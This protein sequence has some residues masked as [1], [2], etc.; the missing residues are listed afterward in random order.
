LPEW[1]CTISRQ[2]YIGSEQKLEKNEY[3]SNSPISGINGNNND[4][5]DDKN[6]NDNDDVN[7]N[8]NNDNNILL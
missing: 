4:N 7:N 1:Y 8:N 3:R 2:L 5:D 6:N